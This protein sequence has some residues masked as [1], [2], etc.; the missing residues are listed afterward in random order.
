MRLCLKKSF[1]TI[2]IIFSAKIDLMISMK[3][4]IL[5]NMNNRI[6]VSFES[7]DILVIPE[8]IVEKFGLKNE[9]IYGGDHCVEIARQ[10]TD[11]RT[12]REW[13]PKNIVNLLHVYGPNVLK[14]TIAPDFIIAPLLHALI[15]CFGDH[16]LQDTYA[17]PESTRGVLWIFL[18]SHFKEVPS[19]NKIIIPLFDHNNRYAW[20][21]MRKTLTAISEKYN[22]QINGEKFVIN[23]LWKYIADELSLMASSISTLYMINSALQ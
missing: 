12:I 14:E 6:V 22:I 21:I 1:N 13:S 20:N 4:H 7:T 19:I 10:Y 17:I 9:I 2:L 8:D 5:N 23:N 18:K 15:I 11:T 3:I 16:L